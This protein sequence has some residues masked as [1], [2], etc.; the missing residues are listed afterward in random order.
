P[1]LDPAMLDA[2]R[3]GAA[4]RVKVTVKAEPT[5]KAAK[6]ENTENRDTAKPTRARRQK[7]KPVDVA[8]AVEEIASTEAAS[9]AASAPVEF[10]YF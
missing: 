1:D 4:E 3:R 6:L 7:A 5:A 9:T 10:G 8:V 2:H